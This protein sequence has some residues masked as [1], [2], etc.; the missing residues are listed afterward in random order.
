M[1]DNPAASPGM[2]GSSESESPGNRREL[3]SAAPRPPYII[4]TS[5]AVKWY[6]PESHSVEAKGYS[7][8]S[9]PAGTLPKPAGSRS[10]PEPLMAA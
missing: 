8:R 1:K 10:L 2:L 9:K 4:D 6:I 7:G 5:V 3:D